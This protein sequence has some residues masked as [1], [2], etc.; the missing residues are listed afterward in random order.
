[1]TN[2]AAHTA[3]TEEIF[4]E[5]LSAKLFM[6]FIGSEVA[7]SSPEINF[8][9]NFTPMNIKIEKKLFHRPSPIF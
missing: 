8:P 1:M 6:V 9:E 4:A 7:S 2:T 5:S 3:V